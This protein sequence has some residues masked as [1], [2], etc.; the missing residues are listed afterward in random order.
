MKKINVLTNVF[1]VAL[2]AVLACSIN[3]ESGLEPNTD[4]LSL[5]EIKLLASRFPDNIKQVS[6]YNGDKL[7]A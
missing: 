3:N 4:M 7:V 6:V 1:I 5:E 2:V